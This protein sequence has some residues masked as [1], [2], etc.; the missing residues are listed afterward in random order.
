MT[1]C[2][3]VW[4]A[5]DSTCPS[6]HARYKLQATCLLLRHTHTLAHTL[7][8]T[9]TSTSES[10]TQTTYTHNHDFGNSNL[11]RTKFC[12]KNTVYVLQQSTKLSWQTT[13]TNN[14]I[15]IQIRRILP[16]PAPSVGVKPWKFSVPVS[17]AAQGNILPAVPQDVPP[18]PNLVELIQ[19]DV[20]FFVMIPPTW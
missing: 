18:P 7:T 20:P 17:A 5:F 11:R 8:H 6:L 3:H 19:T 10:H 16:R 4:H 13:F 9:H 14:F 12:Y 1:F 15:S 2:N